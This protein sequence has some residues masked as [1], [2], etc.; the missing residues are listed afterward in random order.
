MLKSHLSNGTVGNYKKKKRANKKGAYER[1]IEHFVK[2][3]DIADLSIKKVGLHHFENVIFK[4]NIKSATR[5]FYYRQLRVFWNTLRDRNI[6]TG[7]LFKI[8]KK[9][10]PPK[11]ANTRPKM[12]SE[13]ELQEL[14]RAYDKE[15][16]RKKKLPEYRPYFSQQWFKPLICCYFYG[17]L[18]RNEAGYNPDLP[19]SG[20]QGQN[21]FYEDDELAAIYLEATKGR[22]ERLIPIN[23]IWRK[24]LQKYIEVRGMP[25]HEEYLFIYLGG[26]KK[27]WPVTGD[28]AYREFK[29]YLKM[30]D[31]PKS[32]TLHGMRHER[33]TT[34]LED[35][36]NTSEA[37]F[38][39][40]HSSVKTTEAYTHLRGKK[41]LAK[42]RKI[43]QG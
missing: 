42:Q 28:R 22:K 26:S 2:Y 20:L 37:Q 16:E 29:R 32:R 4:P 12:I 17:G 11:K 1:A 23:S 43:E 33:I 14:F 6:V 34:W 39:A 38:M 40:G 24:H 25:K 21:L 10:L 31:L 30:A 19:Y 15:V 8:I 13:N 3:N 18:Q 9:N 7:D 36:F 27:G 35:G 41:L 5:H